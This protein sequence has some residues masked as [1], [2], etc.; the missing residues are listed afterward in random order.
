MCVRGGND[1]K[2]ILA[3]R[4]VCEQ[5]QPVKTLIGFTSAVTHDSRAQTRRGKAENAKIWRRPK[6]I[7]QKHCA[8]CR[9]NVIF[10]L[11]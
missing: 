5:I 7:A 8:R 2:N 6:A 1:S 11:M 3:V 4:E 10:L 9:G